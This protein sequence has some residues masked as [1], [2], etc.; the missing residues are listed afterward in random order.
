MIK[1]KRRLTTFW[2]N[3]QFV[4]AVLFGSWIHSETS[5]SFFFSYYVPWEH[6]EKFSINVKCHIFRTE[7]S[8]LW[9]QAPIIAYQYPNGEADSVLEK[10]GKLTCIPKKQAQLG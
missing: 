8:E 2:S 7:E 9:Y 1:K 4:N 10:H 6:T 3:Q 5:S